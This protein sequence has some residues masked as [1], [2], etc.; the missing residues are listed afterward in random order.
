MKSGIT[1]LKSLVTFLCVPRVY[2]WTLESIFS[3]SGSSLLSWA[4][5]IL[6]ITSQIRATRLPF[7]AFLPW[8]GLHLPL[9]L[10]LWLLKPRVHWRPL[11][12]GMLWWVVGGSGGGVWWGQGVGVVWSWVLPGGRIILSL[13]REHSLSV[14]ID[15]IS[16][17]RIWLKHPKIA[18][19]GK[20]W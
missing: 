5:R 2:L 7:Q 18:L 11:F 19:R 13:L 8:S 6:S 1:I 14:S 10:C 16:S 20:V 12:F 4:T 9:Q 15:F 17:I 3:Q